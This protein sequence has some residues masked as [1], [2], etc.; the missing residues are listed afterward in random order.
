MDEP[1]TF[2]NAVDSRKS[3]GKGKWH[4]KV[5][6]HCDKTRHTKDVCYKKYGFPLG[7]RG[8]VINSTINVI[9]DASDSIVDDR[10]SVKG[11]P[12]RQFSLTS[13]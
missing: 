1:S 6:T 9:G 13:K 5:C 4:V 12:D 3:F 2:I 7:Y 10:T 11:E 8:K